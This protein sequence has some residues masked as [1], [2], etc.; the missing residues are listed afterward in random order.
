MKFEHQTKINATQQSVFDWFER[1]GSFRRLMPPWEVTEEVRADENLKDGAQRV[2]RFPM[3]PIKMTW[4]AEHLGY[5][6]PHRF[7]DVMKKGPFRSWHHVHRFN[8]LLYTSPSPRDGLLSRM[9][10]SA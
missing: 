6:P 4:V 1:R 7:E 3:G 10:S 8:C 9:P 2:F 5:E